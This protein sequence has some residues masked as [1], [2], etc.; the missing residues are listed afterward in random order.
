MHFLAGLAVEVHLDFSPH[1]TDSDAEDTLTSLYQVDDLAGRGALVHGGAIAH[2]RDIGQVIQAS[3]SQVLDGEANL[4]QG[5]AGIEQALH[6]LEHENVAEAVEALGTG[7]GCAAHGGNHKVGAGPVVE[8]A[9]GDTGCLASDGTTVTQVF[10]HHRNGVREEHALFTARRRCRGKERVESVQGLV[11]ARVRLVSACA[12][13]GL[14]LHHGP[15]FCVLVCGIR[16]MP[17]TRLS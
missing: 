5:H 10:L 8:L 6:D 14:V 9:V 13:A 12:L 7:T 16:R 3:A 15:S 2:E 1:A 4:L 11:E 17:V